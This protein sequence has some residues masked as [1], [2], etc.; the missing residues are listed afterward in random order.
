ME[1][2]DKKS[3]QTSPHYSILNVPLPADE[4]LTSYD[5]VVTSVALGYTARLVQLVSGSDFG[6]YIQFL[7]IVVLLL[8]MRVLLPLC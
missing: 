7:V 2:S 3:K 4:T 1:N 6:C 5:E 8:L